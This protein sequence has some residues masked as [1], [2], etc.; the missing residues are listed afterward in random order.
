MQKLSINLSADQKGN[1][2]KT[3]RGCLALY[4]RLLMLPRKSMPTVSK[5]SIFSVNMGSQ[6]NPLLQL[7]NDVWLLIIEFLKTDPKA[8]AALART[9]KVGCN[10]M[11]P[12]IN[13]M[14]KKLILESLSAPLQ[15]RIVL[16]SGLQPAAVFHDQDAEKQQ[17]IGQIL[18][19]TTLLQ[20]NKNIIEERNHMY[21]VPVIGVNCSLEKKF[22]LLI[23]VLIVAVLA[24]SIYNS[25]TK[26]MPNEFIGA[27]C[28]VSALIILTMA[29]LHY[30]NNLISRARS[31]VE[32]TESELRQT[33]LHPFSNLRLFAR[34]Q[35]DDEEKGERR[36]LLALAP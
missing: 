4:W 18:R 25:R 24:G 20:A 36:P 6:N 30:K 14:A 10:L 15:A 33:S 7:P 32:N 26:E 34:P 29:A 22:Y 9:S 21:R 8:M 3:A 17:T 2:I 27:I 1:I 12:S 16:N 28:G 35:L 5:S 11:Q 13:E 23:T 31:E 19:N